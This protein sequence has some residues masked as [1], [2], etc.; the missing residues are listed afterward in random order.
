MRRLC[1]MVAYQSTWRGK[2]RTVHLA[3]S[4]GSRRVPHVERRT[5]WQLKVM[6]LHLVNTYGLCAADID[7]YARA[8]PHHFELLLHP[9]RR[10][11]CV[12]SSRK[13]VIAAP[14]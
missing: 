14:P 11:C 8:R 4:W 10:S 6:R 3:S 13:S 12:G 5:R 2:E 9:I 1:S 7:I